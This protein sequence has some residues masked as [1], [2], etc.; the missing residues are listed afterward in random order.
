MAA[1]QLREL[2]GVRAGDKGDISNVALFAY[3][4][5]AYRAIRREVTAE[6]VK[7]HY[8]D[9]VGGSV[10]RYE[11]PKLL[12]LNFVMQAALGGGGPSSLRTDNLGKSMGGALLR[13]EIAVPASVAANAPRRRPHVDLSVPRPCDVTHDGVAD[14]ADSSHEDADVHVGQ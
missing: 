9:L 12:A 7:E 13:L 10:V 3:S 6:R 4:D 8:G 2:C 11:V 14:D 5:E 1:I